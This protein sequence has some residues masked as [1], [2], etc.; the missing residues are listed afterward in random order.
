[1]Y[2]PFISFAGAYILCL[3]LWGRR[4]AI[5]LQMVNLMAMLGYTAGP[6]FIQLFMYTETDVSNQTGLMST[7]HGLSNV[8]QSSMTNTHQIRY[9]FWILAGLELLSAIGMLVYFASDGCKV[10]SNLAGADDDADDANGTIKRSR[11]FIGMMTLSFCLF[12]VAYAGIEVGYSGLLT[13]FLVK[14]LGFT[15]QQGASV[16]AV[17]QGVN[18]GFTA[19]GIVL[20]KFLQ[21]R[22]LLIF[23]MTMCFLALSVMVLFVNMHPAVPWICSAALGAGYSTVTPAVYA[24]VSTFM[25][26]TGQF[27]GIFWAGFNAGGMAIPTLIGYLFTDI[28]PMAFVYSMLACSVLMSVIFGI[29][30]IVTVCLDRQKSKQTK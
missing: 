8:T 15:N 6:L 16:T 4:A 7:P 27:S 20:S 29:T 28:N 2:F 10:R 24:Y 25:P 30:C 13:V 3:K 11:Y 19:L 5:W 1:M 12:N 14:H 22:T 18:A 9:A 26:I 23:N 21:A 17:L